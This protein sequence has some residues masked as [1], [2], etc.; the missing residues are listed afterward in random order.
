MDEK[1]SRRLSV[2]DVTMIQEEHLSCPVCIISLMAPVY[3]CKQGH[4]I[5]KPCMDELPQ[6]VVCPSCSSN[7][8]DPI[9]C[10]A[11]EQLLEVIPLACEL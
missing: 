9:R 8:S 5:C 11:I 4:I 1:S 3:Q 6:P 7:M 10:R 2:E